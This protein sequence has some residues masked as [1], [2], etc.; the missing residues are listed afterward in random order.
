MAK[1]LQEDYAVEGR[2]YD[3]QWADTKEYYQHIM[4]DCKI[5]NT[6]DIYE[7]LKE[8]N[9]PRYTV[10][11]A[12]QTDMS[13]CL[14]DELKQAFSEL[15][16]DMDVEENDSYYGVKS[17]DTVTEDAGQDALSYVGSARSK[18]VDFS[19]TSQGYYAGNACSIKIDDV[20]YAKQGNGINIV[21]YCNENRRVI[22]SVVY[23]EYLYR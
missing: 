11:I 5:S 8:I 3:A 18:L 6:N 13:S 15:G 10:L 4:D 1:L 21:V 20:E 16:F 14:S 7:Y 12:A 23:N 19:V 2:E 9:N 22:D 17:D